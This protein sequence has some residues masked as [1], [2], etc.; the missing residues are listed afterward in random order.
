MGDP[1]TS[2][3]R[4]FSTTI[5]TEMTA[6]AQRTGAIN[7]GQGFPDTDG[8]PS[9]LAAAASALQ[10]GLNQY[11]PLP[12]I[13]ALRQAVVEQR[14]NRYR[15]AY[16]PDSEVL[17]TVGATEAVASAILA[18]VE[19]GDEV[20]LFEPF[21]DSYGAAIALAGA[22]RRPILLR[23]HGPAGRFTFDPAELRAAIG[24]RTRVLL[25]NSPHNP[26]GTVFDTAEL[27]EIAA[28]AQ[29]RDLV[30]VTDEVYEYLTYDDARHLPIAS[31]P[32]MRERTVSISSA[33]KSF[34]ATG[35][36]VGWVLAPAAHVEAVR[37]VK[38]FLTFAVN[39]AFQ[40]AVATALRQELGWVE[41]LRQN[42]Q[43]RRDQLCLGLAEAGFTVHR[44]QGAYF[45]VADVTPLGTDDA[46]AFA[47]RLIEEA[48]VVA[49]PSQVFYDDREAGRR[50]LRFAF[51]KREAVIA[52]VVTRLRAFADR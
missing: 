27:R 32:G 26:T 43:D 34:S 2:R 36:K 20:A 18:L 47:F 38:Q 1:L 31:L 28:V 21:Y 8:P 45:V 46:R 44:P 11:P 52:D 42:L 6:V 40:Q 25:L 7:L 33:G 37:T 14:A 50:Y 10:A 24:P 49:I 17:I 4:D 19:P 3:M 16:D 35:W 30:V 51:C 22:R 41:R 48:G 29:E 15:L 13:P 9:M 39:G 23:P 5:F 12:G